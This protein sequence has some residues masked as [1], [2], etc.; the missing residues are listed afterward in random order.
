MDK[1]AFINL[2][3][4]EACNRK[5]EAGTVTQLVGWWQSPDSYWKMKQRKLKKATEKQS[6]YIALPSA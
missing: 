4:T 3:R 6:I 2:K 1:V 5:K